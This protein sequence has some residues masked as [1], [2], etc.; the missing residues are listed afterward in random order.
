M[1]I[2]A[3]GGGSSLGG[4]KPATMPAKTGG[5]SRTAAASG[6]S[7]ASATGT[8]EEADTNQDGVVTALEQVTYDLK[9]PGKIQT[10]SLL[11]VKA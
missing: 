2:S 4:M 6:S 10:G 5:A 8:Y 3:I 11:D 1:A 7:S 9:H